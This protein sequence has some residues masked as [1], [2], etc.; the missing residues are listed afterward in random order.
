M[1]FTETRLQG[2]YII[3]VERREDDR[4]FFGRTFCRNEFSTRGLKTH[5]AQCNVSFNK[6]RGTLRGM[7]YQIAPRAEAKQVRCT[8]GKIYD[9]IIDLRPGSPTRLQWEG[10]ELSAENCRSLY[11][12]E[13]FAHGFQTL[14]HDSEVFYQMYEFYAPE[15]A[16]GIRW[17]DP[18]FKIPWPL[19]GTII[20]DRDRSYP[21]YGSSHR[22]ETE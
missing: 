11:V 21:L 5:V 15:Y 8:R 9:V 12:P 7:H 19:P 4:G 3:D 16:R 1:I 6:K 13:G 14:E 10:V 22:E 18:L 20:S 2:A 17:D